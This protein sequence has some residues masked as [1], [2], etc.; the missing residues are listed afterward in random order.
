MWLI[1]LLLMLLPL[2][3]RLLTD[4]DLDFVLLDFDRLRDLD[5]KGLC[6]MF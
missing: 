3:I 4:F 5:L 6:L 1:G 2:V